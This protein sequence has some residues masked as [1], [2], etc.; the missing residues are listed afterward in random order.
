MEPFPTAFLVTCC[1]NVGSRIQV[2]DIDI[3][4]QH[5]IIQIKRFKA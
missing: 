4:N 5:N 3:E 1:V 2:L